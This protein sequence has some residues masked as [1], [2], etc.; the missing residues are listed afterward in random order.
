MYEIILGIIL[1]E[2]V[3]SIN[4]LMKRSGFTKEEIGSALLYLQNK[5]LLISS[6]KSISLCDKCPLSKICK[7]KRLKV[8]GEVYVDRIN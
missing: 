1:N 8:E 4:E 5:G 2:G 7:T 3:I 6:E